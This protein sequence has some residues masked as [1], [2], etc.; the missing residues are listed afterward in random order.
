MSLLI[1][2]LTTSA[3]VLDDL[4]ITVTGAIGT[5]LDLVDLRPNDVTLSALGGDLEAAINGTTP[6]STPEL[7]VVDPRSG[8]TGNLSAANSLIAL[9]AHNDAH[10][11]IQLASIADLDDVGGVPGAGEVLE[12]NSGSG[13]YLPVAASVIGGNI[14]LGDLSDVD[15]L[16][17]H[18]TDAPVI[19]M[20]DGTNFDTVPI[21][22]GTNITGVAVSGTSWTLN[23][24]DVFLLNTGDNL[25]SGTLTIDSGAS[26]AIAT[27]GDLTI[28]DAPVNPTDAANK[29]YVDSVAAGL[30]PKESVRYGTVLDVSG[31]YNPTGGTGGTGAF[32]SVDFTDG[33]IFDGLTAGAIAI[34]DRIL[35]KSQTEISGYADAAVAGAP[36][37]SVVPALSAATYDFDATVDGGA[38]QQLSVTVAATDDYD[39]IAA[40]MSAQVV[41]GSVAF[42]GGS[43]RVTSATTGSSSTVVVAAGTAGSGGGDLF[44]AITA[45]A[46]GNPAVTF[47]TPSAGT[48]SLENGI[49][50]VTTAGATGAM[51]RSSDQDGSP[52]SEVSGGNYTFVENG[53]V[54]ANTGWVLQGDG[55][56]TLN[57]DPISWVQF[58]ESSD[59]SAGPGLELVG[60]QFNL[61][62]DNLTPATIALTDEIAFNDVNDS[63]TTRNT[64]VDDF[65]KD[66]NIPFGFTGTGIIVQTGDDAYTKVAIAVDG[67]GALD[68]LAIANA[69]G[70]AG[71]PT[72]G[73]DINGLP[74]RSDTIDGSDRLAV[75][76][77]TSGANE[78]YTV[79]E[80]ANAGAANAFGIVNGDTGVATADSP[81]DTIAITTAVNGGITTVG[82][83]GTSAALTIG[84]NVA[85]LA[86]GGG[87][88]LAG[89][90][91]A[92]NDGG[93]TVRYTFTDV[94]DDLEIPNSIGTGTGY[95]VSDGGGNYTTNT[96]AVDGVGNKEGLTIVGGDGSATTTIG[97]DIVTNTLAAEDIAAGDLFIAY[98]LSDTANETF[99][100]QEVADGLLT[101]SGGLSNAFSSIAG[102]DGGTTAVAIGGDTITVNGTG[103]NITTTNG[104][105]GADTLDIALDISDLDAGAETLLIGD[106]IAVYDGTAT[107][108]YTF[109]D[110]TTDLEIPNTIGSTAGFIVSDGS[111]NYTTRTISASALEDEDGLIVNATDGSANLTVGLDIVGMTDGAEDMAATDEFAVHNKSEGTGGANRKMTGQDVA[112]GVLSITN[113]TG[114]T[115]STVNGQTVLTYVDS[116]R[117]ETLSVDSFAV[118]YGENRVANNDW[119][120]IG[121]AID[122]LSGFIM[123]MNATIVGASIHSASVPSGN[124]KTFD[125]YVDGAIPTGGTGFLSLTGTAGN[126]EKSASVNTTDINV[127]LG[128]KVRVRG[129]AAGGTI[130]DTVITLWVRWRA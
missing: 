107:L 55:I 101:L 58:S 22:A 130:E 93:T 33:S 35:V 32:T 120:E 34:G 113:L 40:L 53:T 126:V 8:Y 114:L 98:N 85:G 27:G 129:D 111:G 95:V 31:T 48:A 72:V 71:N 24:D 90:E 91:I 92:V 57:T 12:Y 7:V 17:A 73:L 3:V 26:I 46:S 43:F 84:M 54:L 96:I 67:A 37:G 65:L 38:L 87:T 39:A 28:A 64:T 77:I 118:T 18:T 44:A 75:Y 20:G 13:Q 23:V 125:L 112:D 97:L 50:T 63:N 82:V 62:I 49:Y 121:G 103:L 5:T 59:F 68:G 79:T 66:L 119:M 1:Y 109:T 127:D 10:I 99:T 108:E 106:S 70:T 94:V 69:D 56:L 51:E 11:G 110:V 2:K 14:A 100:A 89:D 36:A 104:G 124:T 42:V 15:D 122:A 16:A 29:E 88:I 25:T 115:F 81:A 60:S 9:R 116:T 30:D 52:A 123:P 102:G 47:P 80:I 76:N 74:V 83:A 105:A 4:G 117:G 78:Y 128:E 19:L 45:Q 6:F 86:A 21:S 41:G 61:D